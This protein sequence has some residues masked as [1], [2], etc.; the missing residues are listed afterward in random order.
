MRKLLLVVV[1]L[2]V[3]L[4]IYIPFVVNKATGEIDAATGLMKSQMGESVVLN[5]D[6][7]ELTD[8]D[9]FSNT[10][11]LSNGIEVSRAYYENQKGL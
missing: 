7:L 3:I 4:A 1:V 8:Y 10:Y 9:I 6:T 11:T 5:G 2:A